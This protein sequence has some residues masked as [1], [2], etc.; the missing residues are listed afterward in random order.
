MDDRQAGTLLVAAQ[1][2]CEAALFAPGRRL[3]AE[4]PVT[5]TV[6]SGLVVAG[7][8]LALAGAASLGRRVRAHPDPPPDAVLRTTGV[9]GVVRH[10]IYVG[11][12]V[13][14]VGVAVARARPVSWVAAAG[15]LAVVRAKAAREEAALSDRFGLRHEQYRAVIPPWLPR[16]KT[17]DSGA[18][19]AGG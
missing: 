15:L 14:A 1:G 12:V 13:A 9:Y 2:A 4:G 6:A 17:V 8:T 3:W 10:P 11:L 7:G 16:H 5:R 19:P 18:P